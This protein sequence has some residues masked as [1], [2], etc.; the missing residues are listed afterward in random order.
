MNQINQRNLFKIDPIS[1]THTKNCILY[2]DSAISERQMAGQP[3]FA[4]FLIHDFSN[5][6][7]F[8]LKNYEIRFY[9]GQGG[10]QF[11]KSQLI[12]NYLP[13]LKCVN[14]TSQFAGLQKASSVTVF[15]TVRRP[16]IN[17]DS[18]HFPIQITGCKKKNVRF[19]CLLLTCCEII[20]N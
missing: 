12:F 6:V 17:V 13:D 15:T 5:H 8:V 14:P 10:F 18:P 9:T 16:C 3:P 19:V 4:L 11:V 7:D 1:R 2:S 20:P